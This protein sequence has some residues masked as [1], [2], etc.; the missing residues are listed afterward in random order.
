MPR[1]VAR[2]FSSTIYINRHIRAHLDTKTRVILGPMVRGQ[3]KN[4]A[5]IKEAAD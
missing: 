5:P 3:L 1:D 4:G 2:C